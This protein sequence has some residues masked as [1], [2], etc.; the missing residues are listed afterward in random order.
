MCR[1][2]GKSLG[3]AVSLSQFL[4]IGGRENKRI[5]FD[6][7]QGHGNNIKRERETLN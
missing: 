6:T 1:D 7:L 4:S 3:G 5:L 2:K